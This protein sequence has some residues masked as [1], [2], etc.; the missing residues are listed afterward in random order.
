MSKIKEQLIGYEQS[1]WVGKDDHVKVTELDEYLL[2]S[3]SVAETQHKAREAIRHDLYS[4]PKSELKQLY[5][6]C[7]GDWM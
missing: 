6:D 1:D 2:Y 7:I 3:M 5:R 4:M